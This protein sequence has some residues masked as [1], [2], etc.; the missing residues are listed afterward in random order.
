VGNQQLEGK[1]IDNHR[2]GM[3]WMILSALCFALSAFIVKLLEDIPLMEIVFFRNFASMI[4]VPIILIRKKIPMMGINKP[5]LISRGLLAT[6]GMVGLFYTYTKIPIIDAVTINRLIP[7]FV[8]ILSVLF[9]KE[10]F[11]LQQIYFIIIIA[12]LGVLLVLRPGFRVDI[13]P[14]L[15]GL[16]VTII[17]AIT[18]VILRKLRLTDN[19]W[20]IINYYG[21]IAGF[22]TIMI[23]PNSLELILL[24]LLGFVALNSQIGLTLSYQYASASLVAPY[25]YIQIIFVAILEIGFLRVLPN[26]LT[27]IGSLLII[28][29]GVLNYRLNRFNKNK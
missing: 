20:V 24:L 26:L 27:L 8:I 29:S 6:F 7:F 14:G 9:L 19:Y 17:G 21:Y 23:I 1:I 28:I 22:T 4:I 3:L 16:L 25:L 15:I 12:F 11:Y 10:K 13:L 2:L 5:L 18:H